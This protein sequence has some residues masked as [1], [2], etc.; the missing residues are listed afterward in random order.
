MKFDMA[1]MLA[2]VPVIF[3]TVVQVQA[4]ADALKASGG[5]APTGAQKK[6]AVQDIVRT[7]AL[8]T[9]VASGKQI[10]PVDET[11]AA[12]GAVI[13]SI[14]AFLKVNTAVHLSAPP[15]P[16]QTPAPAGQ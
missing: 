13:D 16:A 2:L 14:V 4:D 11:V 1:K 6:L 12:S 9:N 5:V 8:T 3:A 7:A 15:A 10:I